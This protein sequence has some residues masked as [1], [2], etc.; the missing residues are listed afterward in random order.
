M[1]DT[2]Y[3]TTELSTLTP[4]EIKGA[5]DPINE[6]TGFVPSVF[7]KLTCKG[8]PL[9]VARSMAEALEWLAHPAR[10][11]QDYACYSWIDGVEK[12]VLRNGGT[13]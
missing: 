12:E 5:P 7:Y 8:E 11:T 13:S 3:V 2:E 10:Q 6:K 9:M 1:S 4:A